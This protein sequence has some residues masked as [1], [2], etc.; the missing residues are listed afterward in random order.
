MVHSYVDEPNERSAA[1]LR[2]QGYR[3][4]GF[5]SWEMMG[6]GRMNGCYVFDLLAAEW[7]AARK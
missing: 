4:C 6:P 1:A 7:R 5:F 2:K 3:D